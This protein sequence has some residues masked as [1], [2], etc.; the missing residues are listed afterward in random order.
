M[1]GLRPE[2]EAAWRLVRPHVRRT[3]VIELLAG[4]LGVA[5]PLALK[6]ESLQ[7]SG[8]FKGRGAFHKL[9]ASKVPAA[10][11]R[12]RIGWQPWR[13]R[14]LCRARARAQGRD[15]R[16]DRRLA[17]QGRTVSRA[18]VPIVHQV[19]CGLCRGTGAVGEARGRRPVR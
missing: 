13:G 4:V 14:G 6:L 2:V 8:S 7:L 15:L 3:P 16:P 9:L 11:H 19:G 17:D 5:A 10:G 12:R 1:I 18:T